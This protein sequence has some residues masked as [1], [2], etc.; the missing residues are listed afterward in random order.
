MVHLSKPPE[1]ETQSSPPQTLPELSDVRTDV[2]LDSLTSGRDRY[3]HFFSN[4]GKCLYEEKTEKNADSNMILPPLC[5]EVELRVQ[6]ISV[7][8]GTQMS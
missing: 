4:L 7:C 5:V 8:I 6:E 2:N 1:T 3:C